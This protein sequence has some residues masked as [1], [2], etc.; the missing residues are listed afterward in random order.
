MRAFKFSAATAHVFLLLA[1]VAPTV[2][3]ADGTNCM[4]QLANA[5]KKSGLETVLEFRDDAKAGEVGV[6]ANSPALL[7]PLWPQMESCLN[8]AF[9]QQR[10]G[11]GMGRAKYE[12]RQWFNETG[13]S[14]ESCT[15]MLPPVD[16]MNDDPN[17]N[18]HGIWVRCMRGRSKLPEGMF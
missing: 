14:Y 12:F 2:F 8:A 18:E 17:N 3:A 1:A 11:T 15:S 9:S 4:R 7:T 13:G 16:K 6:F 5:A 10:T